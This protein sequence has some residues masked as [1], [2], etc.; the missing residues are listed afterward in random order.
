MN[1]RAIHRSK[2]EYRI[3]KDNSHKNKVL[4]KENKKLLGKLEGPDPRPERRTLDNRRCVEEKPMPMC[5]YTRPLPE[6]P[7]DE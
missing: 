6:A 2:A 1:Y 5:E 3:R 4:T 7:I